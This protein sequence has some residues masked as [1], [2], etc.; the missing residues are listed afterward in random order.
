MPDKLVWRQ[1][2]SGEFSVKT[3]YIVARKVLGKDSTINGSW[4]E[5]WSV[6]WKATVAS[7]VKLFAWRLIQGFIPVWS[8]LISRGVHVQNCCCMCASSDETPWHVFF[9]CKFSKEV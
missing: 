8:I 1:S 6:I 3:G 2:E 5:V 4:R 7:K 9:D